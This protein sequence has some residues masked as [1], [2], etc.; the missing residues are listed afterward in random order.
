MSPGI[1]ISAWFNTYLEQLASN[2]PRLVAISTL[3][4]VFGILELLL[5]AQSGQSLLGRMRNITFTLILIVGGVALTSVIVLF[6]KVNPRVYAPGGPSQTLL[7]LSA[8]LLVSD[9]LFYWYHRA[10]HSFSWFWPIHELHHSD[11]EL[12]VTTGMRS[13]FLEYPIQTI[14]LTLPTMLIVGIDPVA[15]VLL[16]FIMVAWLYFGHANLKV[17]L[18]RASKLICGPQVHRIHHSNLAQHRDKN[19]AQFFPFYDV[20]FGTY[21]EPAR[22]E[23]PTTGTVTLAS[24]APITEAMMKPFRGWW[25]GRL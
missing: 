7:V 1:V 19:F 12:N 21:Y 11:A 2:I 8:T 13:Y 4:I 6:I 5:P 25:R 16:P 10:Q 22:D 18:G 9:F 14:C 24:D 17:S 15:N 3:F 20:W 23:Y